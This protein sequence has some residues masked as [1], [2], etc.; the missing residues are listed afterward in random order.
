MSASLASPPAPVRQTSYGQHKLTWV[1]RFGV[2]LSKRAVVKHLPRRTELSVVDLG[3]GYR[4]SLLQALRPHL[5]EGVGVD[6][7]IDPE[8]KNDPLLSFQEGSLETVLP[9]LETARFDVVLFISVLEHLRHPLEALYHCHRLLAPGGVLLVNVPT[10]RGKFF[11]EFSAF[12][13]GS[14]PAEEM[15]D[16]K[17][18]YDVRDLWPLLVEAGFRPSRLH[19]KYH[20]FGMNLLA[21]AKKGA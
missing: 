1:D 8:R 16:H 5:R 11:L 4:A 20:K 3:C 15:D 2:W 10:W 21:V 19:L 9:G 12:R 7:S 17:M 18:Y 6:V 14:S 13:L